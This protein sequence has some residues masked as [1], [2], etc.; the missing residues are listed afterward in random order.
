M[1]LNCCIH[2][3][4][5]RKL[6]VALENSLRLKLLMRNIMVLMVKTMMDVNAARC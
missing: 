4:S 3:R 1:R 2:G 6:L 5:S